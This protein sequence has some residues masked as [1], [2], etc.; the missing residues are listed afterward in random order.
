MAWQQT[1]RKSDPHR[2]DYALLAWP[3]G[4]SHLLGSA[5]TGKENTS[6]TGTED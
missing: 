6:R 1:E 3:L 2:H 5:G 4:F